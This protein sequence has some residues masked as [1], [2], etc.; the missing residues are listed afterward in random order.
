MLE[1]AANSMLWILL[2]LAVP[3]LLVLMYLHQRRRQQAFAAWA[4]QRGWQY[5][6]SDTALTSLWSGQPFG[7]GRSRRATEVLTG[8]FEGMPVTSFTYRWTTGERQREQTD[9]RHVVAVWLPAF[10]PT[11]EITPDGLGAKLAKAVGGQDLRFESEE[12]NRTWRVEC[13]LPK[14]ASDVVHP[15]LMERLLEPDARGESMRIE[16][17]AILTW[18]YGAT[19][20]DTLPYRIGLLLS[21]VRTIPRHVWLEHG[22]DP[23]AGRAPTT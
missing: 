21:V 13:R 5:A 22:Y 15:R 23:L 2:V 14:F 20:L 4:A 12:F 17:T 6:A 19:D 10:L 16:G 1:T 7:V 9:T 3:G 11:L 18:A 8:T